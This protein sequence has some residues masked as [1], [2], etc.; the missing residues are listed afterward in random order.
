MEVKKQIKSILNQ[1][2]VYKVQGLLREAMDDYVRAG[3]MIQKHAGLIRNHK[4]LLVSLN[5]KISAIRADIRKLENAPN[6]KEMPE[7]VQRIIKERF[8]FSENEE[9]REL[10]GALALARFGQCTRALEELK[11][12]LKNKT[13]CA[14]AAKNILR[15]QM[16]MD[17]VD[18]ALQQYREWMEAGIFNPEEARALRIFFQ[19]LLHKKGREVTLPEMKVEGALEEQ[20]IPLEMESPPEAVHPEDLLDISSV[21]IPLNEGAA[22]GR[23]RECDVCFQSGNILNLLIPDR[24]TEIL[25]ILEPNSE[26]EPVDF[27]SPIAMFE[28]KAKVL[29]KKKLETGPKKGDFSIDIQIVGLL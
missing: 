11:R 12:L 10:D 16:T 15:C 5:Q 17:A 21:G 23:T 18:E 4:G 25:N 7:Q 29:S 14:E 6:S 2:E 20:E 19:N 24:E 26:L 8:A 27:F 9:T 22:A 1:A 13:V 3:K 28:G